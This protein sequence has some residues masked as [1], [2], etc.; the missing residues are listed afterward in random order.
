VNVIS[1][2]GLPVMGGTPDPRKGRGFQSHHRENLATFRISYYPE[3]RT[4]LWHDL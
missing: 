4:V 1:S 2:C 3:T